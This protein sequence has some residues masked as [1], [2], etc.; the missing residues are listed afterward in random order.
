MIGYRDM[1]F[2]RGGGCTKF[3]KCSKAL[4]EDVKANARKWWN[5]NNPPIAQFVN[6][7]KLECYENKTTNG[8]P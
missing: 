1:T 2:C 6:P 7:K 8:G 3:D 5:G 4:T